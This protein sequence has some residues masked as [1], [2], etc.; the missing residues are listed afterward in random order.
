MESM[1]DFIQFFNRASPLTDLAAE[2]LTDKLQT[3]TY[4]KETLLHKSGDTCR[5]LYF[6]D[7]G[8]TKTFFVKGEKEFIMRFF[9]EQSLFTVMDSFVTEKPS[10]FAVMALEPTAV[11]YILKSD[12]EALANKHHCIET[13]FRKVISGAP[14]AMMKRV[15]EM[16]EENASERYKHFMEEQGKLLQRI[17]LGDLAS[18]L[19]ITQVSLSRIRAK[20]E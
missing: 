12:L 16:L 5:K 4:K 8:L 11:T 20:K 7:E 9:A 18:Y 17:S 13:G 3:K 1:A 15:S 6:I 14:V 19:G 10:N 2:D